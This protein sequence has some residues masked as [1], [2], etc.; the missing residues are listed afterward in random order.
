MLVALPKPGTTSSNGGRVNRWQSRTPR[1]GSQK[2]WPVTPI[3]ALLADDRCTKAVLAF[4]CSR[5]VGA[6]KLEPIRISLACQFIWCDFLAYNSSEVPH[7]PAVFLIAGP[8]SPAVRAGWQ[9]AT[10]RLSHITTGRLPGCQ[11]LSTEVNLSCNHQFDLV[12]S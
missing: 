11:A 4:L 3:A 8:K 1:E 6:L 9:K 7:A 5:K 10:A 12:T 2:R